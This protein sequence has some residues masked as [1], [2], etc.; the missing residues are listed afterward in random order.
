MSSVLDLNND[1]ADFLHPNDSG[2]KK[3]ADAWFS[4]LNAIL[5]SGWI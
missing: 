5:G 2:Y 3:M 4:G 1:L